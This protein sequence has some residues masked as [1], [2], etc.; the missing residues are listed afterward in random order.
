MA[1]D[2]GVREFEL[3]MR[4]RNNLIKKRRVQLGLSQKQL[5]ERIGVSH[6]IVSAYENIAVDPR[7]HDGYSWKRSATLLAKALKVSAEDLW[8]TT[9]TD[10]VS[11]TVTSEFSAQ[12][13]RAASLLLQGEEPL[14]PEDL[15]IERERRERAHASILGMLPDLSPKERQMALDAEIVPGATG[16]L[17]DEALPRKRRYAIETALIGKVTQHVERALAK[18]RRDKAI[19]TQ[20]RI[21]RADLC[22]R[23]KSVWMGL[24]D[25][26]K[27]ALTCA[28]IAGYYRL[29]AANESRLRRSIHAFYKGNG[30]IEAAL[31]EEILTA[32]VWIRAALTSERV[33]CTSG[34]AGV[35]PKRAPSKQQKRRLRRLRV[36]RMR[37]RAKLAIECEWS[38]AQETGITARLG[39]SN[40]DELRRIH[41]R[42]L[43]RLLYE[44]SPGY[45]DPAADVV[46]RA[47]RNIRRIWLET[48]APLM[49]RKGDL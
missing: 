25:E 32:R 14:T 6:A 10:I 23:A 21:A 13:L 36:D 19:E 12:E 17:A 28:N 5:A 46:L 15:L 3:T 22:G 16:G 7:T 2:R 31:I 42:R 47:Q 27:T 41:R 4:V 45:P 40:A 48:P 1:G 34:D 30:A 49:A 9:V 37:E 18:Q 38:A 20:V 35:A 44:I 43:M 29:A 24:S 39:L 26:C 11:N 8:P 33:V